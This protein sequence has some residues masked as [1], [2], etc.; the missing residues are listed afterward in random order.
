MTTIRVALANV[1]APL[2]REDSLRIVLESMKAAFD[3]DAAII[4]F[5]ECLVPGYRIGAAASLPDQDWLNQYSGAVLE[6]LP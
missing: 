2:N 6:N 1:R 3:G 4:C 5:P